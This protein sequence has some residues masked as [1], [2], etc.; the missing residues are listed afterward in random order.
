MAPWG[1][2]EKRVGNNPWSIA[3][4]AGER[5]PMVLDIANTV[6]ARGK[7]Y[8]AR[9]RGQKIPL[10]WA[11]DGD[12]EP[13]TD[14]LTALGG[15]ILPMGGHK[16]Y[17]VAVMMDVLSGVLTGSGFG[18][19]VHGPYQASQKSGAGHLMIV[20]DVAAFQPLAEFEAR[21]GTL[22][23]ELKSAPLAKG[24][25]EILYPGELEARNEAE[26]RARGLVLPQDTLAGLRKLAEETGLQARLPF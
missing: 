18:R 17:G 26:N 25:S 20:L 22:I 16:G 7:I 3:A 1:G 10:G 9:Q 21:M 14:P 19:G 15:I 24:A 12:G 6:V 23:D 13:T 11:I 5:A 4:P 8:L 2:R